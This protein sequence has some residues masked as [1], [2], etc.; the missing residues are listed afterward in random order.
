MSETSTATQQK[1]MSR[2]CSLSL[3]KWRVVGLHGIQ[4]DLLSWY[5]FPP[6]RHEEVPSTAAT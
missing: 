2:I 4:L 3:E 6:N 1:K 5:V